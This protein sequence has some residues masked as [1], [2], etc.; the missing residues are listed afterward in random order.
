M[1][2]TGEFGKGA[3]DEAVRSGATP[4]DLVDGPGLCNLLREY[5]MGVKVTERIVE[6]IVVVPEFFDQF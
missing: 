5:G 2:T 1:I 4:I 6:E 3:R